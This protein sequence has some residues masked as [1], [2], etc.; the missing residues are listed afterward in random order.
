MNE[1][2]YQLKKER[3]FQNKLKSLK[4]SQERR[5][6]KPEYRL[7]ECQR[8][9]RLSNRRTLNLFCYSSNNTKRHELVKFLI[10]MHLRNAGHNVYTEPI[11]E[12]D[13]GR[14]DVMDCDSMII[15]EVTYSETEEELNEKVKKYPEC[16]EVIRIDAK[17]KF[18][19]NALVI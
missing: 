11:L 18:N 2:D 1:E 15:Y 3:A 5:K 17:E 7:I 8:Y 16:F 13:K 10:Y 4:R 12:N 6:D 14:P 19:S 9:I